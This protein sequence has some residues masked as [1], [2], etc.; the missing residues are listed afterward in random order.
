MNN[1]TP[2]IIIIRDWENDKQTLGKCTVYI[3]G[4]PVFNSLSIER[5][6]HDNKQNVSCIPL[7]KYKVVFEYSEKFGMK[8]WEVKNVFGRSEIKFHWGNFWFNYLGCIGLGQKL[9]DINK[10]GIQD[11][12]STKNTIKAFHSALK[13]YT[14]IDLEIKECKC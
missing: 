3:D 11:V 14:E 8:L 13:N 12:T 1:K 6:W 4:K 9:K 10:D 2:K 5:G 7:G